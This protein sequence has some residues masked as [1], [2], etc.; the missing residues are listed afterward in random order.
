M[1]SVKRFLVALCMASLTWPALGAA[2]D[3]TEWPSEQE[4]ELKQLDQQL[5]QMQKQRFRLLFQENK[6]E[7][8]IERL[9]E[10]FRDVQKRRGELLRAT[11]RM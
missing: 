3:A 5:M 8:A 2:Q 4:E 11:G 7:K 9:N 6:D 1:R 10:Q